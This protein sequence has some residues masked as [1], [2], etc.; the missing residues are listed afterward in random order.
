MAMCETEE[1]R[2]THPMSVCTGS[3]LPQN[4]HEDCTTPHVRRMTARRLPDRD[5]ALGGRARHQKGPSWLVSG[6]MDD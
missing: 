4:A 6:L 1:R 3:V 2:M 5:P